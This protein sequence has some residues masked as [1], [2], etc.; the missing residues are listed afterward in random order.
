MVVAMGTLHRLIEK[1]GKQAT[2]QFGDFCWTEVEAAAAYMADEDNA[3]GYLYSGWCQ[4]ALPHRRL[5][6]EKGWQVK[7]GPVALIVQPGM[8]FGPDNDPI[9]V[10]VPYGYPGPGSS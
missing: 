7:S 4:A 8:R 5:P 3:I 9:S 6:D 1:K 10:G 2:L